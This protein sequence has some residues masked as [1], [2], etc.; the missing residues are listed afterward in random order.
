[1]RIVDDPELYQMMCQH[2]RNNDYDVVKERA[3]KVIN[4][5]ILD[6]NRSFPERR[7]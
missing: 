6:R 4:D 7:I 5:S 2:I 3:Q 1:M